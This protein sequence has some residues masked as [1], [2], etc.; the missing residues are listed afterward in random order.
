MSENQ[1]NPQPTSDPANQKST[2][3]PVR[4]VLVLGSLMLGTAL[5]TI[6]VL[7]VLVTMFE[8]KQEARTPFV[9]VVEVNETSTDPA[10]WGLNWPHEFDQYKLTAGD[11]FTSGSSAMPRSKLEAHPW[12]KRMYA[13]YA[14]SIDYRQARGH[15][16]MLYDQVEIGRAHV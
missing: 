15:A 10:P 3:H 4:R 2:V 7:V 11:H 13:G 5:A 9:R 6:I 16:Y 8:H 1:N 14:F 12:L